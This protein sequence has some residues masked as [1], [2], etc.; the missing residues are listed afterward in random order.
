MCVP[1]CYV[2]LCVPVLSGLSY[3]Q[4]SAGYGTCFEV[5]DVEEHPLRQICEEKDL[6]GKIFFLNP[7]SETT[8]ILINNYGIDYATVFTRLHF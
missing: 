1:T 7:Y 3:S 5:K 8:L 2:K 4:V 6:R